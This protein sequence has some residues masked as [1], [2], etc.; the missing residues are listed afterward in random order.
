LIQGDTTHVNLV[1]WIIIIIL[2]CLSDLGLARGLLLRSDP[3]QARTTSSTKNIKEI[4]ETKFQELKSQET[5]NADP[6][7]VPEN[8]RC[9]RNRNVIIYSQDAQ[10]KFLINTFSY[11]SKTF[12]KCFKLDIFNLNYNQFFK[13]VAT[14]INN[15]LFFSY[16]PFR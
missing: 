11:F 16:K 2:F 1:Y 13:E 4:I 9:L 7:F 8:I 10:S 12:L 14:N 5:N 15:I 6:L 3:V